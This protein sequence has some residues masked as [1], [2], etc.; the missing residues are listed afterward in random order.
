MRL[1]SHRIVSHRIARPA[2][3]KSVYYGREFR[4]LFFRNLAK[5]KFAIS[6]ISIEYNV[7]LLLRDKFVLLRYKRRRKVC[8]L[9][10]VKQISL[11]KSIL[12]R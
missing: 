9:I 4:F 8:F 2:L 6:A 11:W 12:Q 7:D 5:G 10:N 3:D 1:A